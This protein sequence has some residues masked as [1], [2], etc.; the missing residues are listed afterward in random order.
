MIDKDLSAYAAAAW[1][2]YLTP[3]TELSKEK[4][5]GTPLVRSAL[6]MYDF[7]EICASTK[8]RPLRTASK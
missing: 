5:N 6:Q 3:V 4:A 1:G 8:G 7:D 2:Q